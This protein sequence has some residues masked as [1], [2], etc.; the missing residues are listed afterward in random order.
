MNLFLNGQIE[1]PFL[2]NIYENQLKVG[3]FKTPNINFDNCY[4]NLTVGELKK[5]CE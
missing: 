5:N 3:K 4:N 1:S 2:K